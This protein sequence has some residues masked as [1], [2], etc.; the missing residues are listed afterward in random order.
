MVVSSSTWTYIKL[1]EILC[2]STEKKNLYQS[3]TA[4]LLLT[5]AFFNI[6]NSKTI[7]T[8]KQ[9]SELCLNVTEATL[10]TSPP[11]TLDVTVGE[12]IVLPCQVTHDPSL[13]L[14]FTWFFN[15]Q[16]IQF[17]RHG[18]YFEKVGS[19]SIDTPCITCWLVFVFFIN[20]T[21][22]NIP[23]DTELTSKT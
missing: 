10:I 9:N 4:H 19:V 7:F 21:R 16:L 22:G 23:L 17:G 6:C 2:L 3:F 11:S 8:T 18:G 5:Y 15:E 20:V 13:E 1:I 12:S 14:K